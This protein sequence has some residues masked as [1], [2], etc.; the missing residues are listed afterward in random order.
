MYFRDYDKSNAGV[1]YRRFLSEL[2][3]FTKPSS[4]LEIGTRNGNSLKFVECDSIL[5]DPEFNIT[6]NVFASKRKS[7]LFFQV[8]SDYFF[9]NYKLE[10][11]IKY[12]IDMAFLD[13]MHQFEYLLRDFINVEKHSHHGSIILMHDVLPLNQ[14]MTSR[15]VDSVGD[16]EVEPNTFKWWTG[17]VWKMI[18][19]L[20]EYRKD[21]HVILIDCPPTGLLYCTGLNSASTILQE[22]YFE[23]VSKYSKIEFSVEKIAEIF[24][25]LDS[26]LLFENKHDFGS[27]FKPFC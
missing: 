3:Q 15:R 24:P 1:N 17:D 20:S 19:I 2:H 6:Q 7:S 23:I 9:S 26:N 13:G 27:I 21:L 8:T 12:P 22:N 25:I 11:L 10:H 16:R 18:L 14:R 4:Y 5:I